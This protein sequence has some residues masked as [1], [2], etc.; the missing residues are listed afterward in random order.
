MK[1]IL[2]SEDEMRVFASEIA[3]NIQPGDILGLIGELGAGKTTFVKCLAKALEITSR[4][5]SPTFVIFKPY[6]IDIKT[7]KHKNIKTFVH[8]DAYRIEGEELQDV[9]IEDYFEDGSVLAIEWADKIKKILPV[10]RT[11]WIRFSLGKN[12]NERIVEF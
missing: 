11:K 12:E 7:K 6:Q 5:V 2:K 10:G 3:K 4:V 1:K 8:V 9:G